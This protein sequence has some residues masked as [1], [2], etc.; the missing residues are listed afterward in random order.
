MHRQWTH[1]F[2]K[3]KISMIGSTIS[4]GQKLPGCEIAPRMFREA[5]LITALKECGFQIRDYGDI[6]E[7]NFISSRPTDEK[8][9]K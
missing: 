5:G 4:S 3:K 6:L 8:L 9:G 7:K 2:C 1:N